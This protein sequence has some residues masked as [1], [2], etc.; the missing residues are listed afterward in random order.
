MVLLFLMHQCLMFV[1][2]FNSFSIKCYVLQNLTTKIF[3]LRYLACYLYFDSNS[4]DMFL[5][6]SYIFL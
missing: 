5:I 3:S 6:N 2:Y 1:C 4:K